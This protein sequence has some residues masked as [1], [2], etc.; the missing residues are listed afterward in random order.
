MLASISFKL[1][2]IICAFISFGL[3]PAWF[4]YKFWILTVLDLNLCSATY[5]LRGLGTYFNVPKAP[6]PYDVQWG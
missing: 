6:F 1:E 5:Y 2:N 4:Y 3:D